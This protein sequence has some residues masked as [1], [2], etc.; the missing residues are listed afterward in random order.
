[1]LKTIHLNREVSCDM[2]TEDLL[3]TNAAIVYCSRPQT[4]VRKYFTLI[5]AFFNYS[6]PQ[7]AVV[8][9][10]SVSQTVSVQ[11][12]SRSERNC[13]IFLLLRLLNCVKS[14]A[15]LFETMGGKKQMSVQ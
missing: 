12:F 6:Q 8:N 14:H 1:M 2:A 7:E 11:R 4:G 10:G 9:H 13:L 5:A 15:F 3:G